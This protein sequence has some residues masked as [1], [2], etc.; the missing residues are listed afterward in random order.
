MFEVPDRFIPNI[1]QYT[2]CRKHGRG[3]CWSLEGSKGQLLFGVCGRRARKAGMT[4]KISSQSLSFG[5]RRA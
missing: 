4:G 2:T 3:P 1:V 5:R